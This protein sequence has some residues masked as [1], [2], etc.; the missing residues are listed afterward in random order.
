MK[1]DHRLQ[2]PRVLGK[3]RIELGIS[4]KELAA[5]AGMRQS[6]LCALEIGR[7][8]LN[9]LAHLQG[10]QEALSELPGM[11][12][13]L[14]RA[15]QHD[16]LITLLTQFELSEAQQAALSRMVQA[17][18]LLSDSESEAVAEKFICI[19]EAKTWLTPGAPS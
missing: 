7:T 4:Q 12:D 10:L 15:A 19:Y 14:W 5:R 13:Q 18:Q 11:S 16:R 3:A 6:Q 8:V 9:G 2:V 1:R 17:L